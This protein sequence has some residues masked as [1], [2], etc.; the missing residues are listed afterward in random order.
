MTQYDAPVTITPTDPSPSP[1]PPAPAPAPKRRVSRV[2][3]AGLVATTLTLGG[4]AYFEQDARTDRDEAVGD[5]EHAAAQL[6]T[7]RSRTKAAE[8]TSR[9]ARTT[10][11]AVAGEA[12]MFVDMAAPFVALGDQGLEAERAVQAIGPDPAAVDE[13]NA[14]VDTANAIV[15]QYNAELQALLDRIDD[16]RGSLEA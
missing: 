8:A 1:E 15:D 9:L 7:Q 5:R 14:A 16:L 10:A 11:R 4:A 12:T 13:Y 6:A 2:L 3:F